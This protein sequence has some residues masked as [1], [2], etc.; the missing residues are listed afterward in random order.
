MQEFFFKLTS[1]EEIGF[2]DEAVFSAIKV[3]FVNINVK[4]LRLSRLQMHRD[5]EIKTLLK[6]AT[7]LR[8]FELYDNFLALYYDV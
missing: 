2:F 6:V 4:L 8:Q 3:V 1:K 5:R 7:P